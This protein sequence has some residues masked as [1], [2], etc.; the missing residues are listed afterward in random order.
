MYGRSR[1]LISTMARPRTA[2]LAAL[3]AVWLIGG[4]AWAQPAAAATPSAS[5]TYDIPAGPLGQAL[6]RFAEQSG[7]SLSFDPALVAGK[8]TAGLGG[9]HAPLDAL[10]KLLAG[11][12]LRVAEAGDGRLT[13]VGDGKPSATLPGV[14]VTGQS[15]QDDPTVHDI[16]T[17]VLRRRPATAG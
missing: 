8:T 10:A 3:L 2:L 14:T 9:S 7:L 11:S 15:R 13:L 12:G 16:S 17:E 6:A 1:Q 5:A 4:L